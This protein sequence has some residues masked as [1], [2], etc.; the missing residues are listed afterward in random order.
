MGKQSARSTFLLALTAVS[1]WATLS[2]TWGEQDPVVTAVIAPIFLA[3]IFFTMRFTNRLTANLVDR[4]G[5]KP[6]EPPPPTP[7]SS[8]RP[9]HAQPPAGAAPRWSRTSELDHAGRP[10]GGARSPID[11][12]QASPKTMPRPFMMPNGRSSMSI[13]VPCIAR[14][15]SVR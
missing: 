10:R 12:G 13:A 14:T 15:E 5:P 3:I 8:A 4:F 1:V 11:A 6:P 7:P 2:V 9:E